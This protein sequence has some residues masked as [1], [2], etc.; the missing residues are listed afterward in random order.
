M[1]DPT[2]NPDSCVSCHE[3]ERVHV[4]TVLM[5]RFNFLIVFFGVVIVGA[6]N[7]HDHI[8]RGILLG[9][10]TLIC[11]MI[12]QTLWRSQDKLDAVFDSMVAKFPTHPIKTSND[13]A[14]KIGSSKRYL[15]GRCVPWTC[16]V[17]L[18]AGAVASFWLA[19]C[20]ETKGS[21]HP[22]N[23]PAVTPKAVSPRQE[24]V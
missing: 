3:N 17:V 10:S 1:S 9:V 11:F 21:G 12:A 19:P 20:C 4:E 2:C 13:A 24:G 6:A 23:Q 7:V 14:N 15:V 16:V 22:E 5:Q 18:F 8:M